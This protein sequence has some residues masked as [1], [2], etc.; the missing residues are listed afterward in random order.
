MHSIAAMRA[1]A[2]KCPGLRLI[3]LGAPADE[4][5]TALVRESIREY[6]LE[7]VVLM[8]PPT[9]TVSDELKARSELREASVKE[10][11]L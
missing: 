11:G 7:T 10:P 2:P 8:C 6:G 3:L 4:S 1:L 5:Y 9:D